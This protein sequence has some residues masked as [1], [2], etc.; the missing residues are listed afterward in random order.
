MTNNVLCI[1]HLL[2]LHEKKCQ[3]YFGVITSSVAEIMRRD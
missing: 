2:K 3:N 1:W